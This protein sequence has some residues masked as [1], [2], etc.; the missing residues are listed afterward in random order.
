MAPRIPPLPEDQWT[1]EQRAVLVATSATDEPARGN[2]YQALV[3][4]PKLHARWVAFGARLLVAGR[5]PARARE[6]LVLRTAWRTG[7]EYYWAPHVELGREAGITADEVEGVVQGPTWP[8]WDE[9][10]RALVAAADE[11]VDDHVVGDA[12]WAVLAAHLDEQQL[13]EVPFLVGHYVM[14]AGAMR[15]MGVELE[16]GQAGFEAR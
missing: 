2:W 1:E 7:A 6:L 8:G 10:D 13:L 15:S 16:P 9:L 5:L 12:T 14:V 4:H 11:L 3:R